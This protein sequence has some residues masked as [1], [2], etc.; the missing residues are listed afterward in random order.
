MAASGGCCSFQVVNYCR[1]RDKIM[2]R[3]PKV[4]KAYWQGV[5]QEYDVLPPSEKE[6]LQDKIRSSLDVGI[7]E[8]K[9]SHHLAL[10]DTPNRQVVA[11]S[12]PVGSSQTMVAH[13]PTSLTLMPTDTTKLRETKRVSFWN[14]CGSHKFHT[15]RDGTL[16]PVSL[17]CPRFAQTSLTHAPD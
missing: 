6:V 5:R 17:S 7:A 8:R 9:R 11:S 14:N 15:E 4:T 3:C 13:V 10:T 1:Q 16:I 12:C 2:N